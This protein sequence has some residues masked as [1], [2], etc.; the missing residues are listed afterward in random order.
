MYITIIMKFNIIASL[1]KNKGIGR[2]GYIP[3]NNSI[4][5]S[6]LFSKLTRGNGNNAVVMGSN[7]YDNVFIE[8]YK[9]FNGRQNLVLSKYMSFNDESPYSNLEFFPNTDK[10]LSNCQKYKYDEV[11]IIGGETVFYDFM[12]G[13][14]NVP[15]KNIYLNYINNDYDCDSFFPMRFDENQNINFINTSVIDNIEQVLVKIDYNRIPS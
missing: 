7:T 2:N 3:W 15:I 6:N 12:S 14:N 9:P 8:G 13:K 4:M 10:L 1:C 5:Y 11:W